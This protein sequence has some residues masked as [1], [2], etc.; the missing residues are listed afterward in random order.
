MGA[1]FEVVTEGG[2]FLVHVTRNEQTN[3]FHA[4][5]QGHP[6]VEAWAPSLPEVLRKIRK[7]ATFAVDAVA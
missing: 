1:V 3:L 2:P 6:A 4:K 5:A 7:R